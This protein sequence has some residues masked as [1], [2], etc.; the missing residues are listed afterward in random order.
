MKAYALV[1]YDDNDEI[2]VSLYDNK[3]KAKEALS[4][5]LE[6]AEEAQDEIDYFCDEV[7]TSTDKYGVRTTH[8]VSPV[9]DKRS[10]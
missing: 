10:K 5:H 1:I 7:F 6:L 2:L 9:V 3:K 4:A 8:I